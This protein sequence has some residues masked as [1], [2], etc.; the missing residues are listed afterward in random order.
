MS[1]TSPDV[2]R[3][4][5]VK[6]RLEPICPLSPLWMYRKGPYYYVRMRPKGLTK[7]TVTISLRTSNRRYAMSQVRDLQRRMEDFHLDNPEAELPALR[8]KLREFALETLGRSVGRDERGAAHNEY[9]DLI[10][11]MGE[12]SSTHGLTPEQLEAIMM[13]ARIA[14]AG[15]SKLNGA[16]DELREII[17]ELTPDEPVATPAQP[18][19][20]PLGED[21]ALPFS[22]LAGLYMAEQQGNVQASTL[23]EIKCSCNTIAKELTDANGAELNLRGHTR[24]DMN[25]LKA[26]LLEGRKASTVNKLLTR[27]STVM[28]WAVNNGYLERSFDKGLK[29]TKGADSTR[30]PFAKAQVQKL[31]D[32]ANKMPVSSWE[33]WALTIGAI[34]GAR[35]GEIYQLTKDDVVRLDDEVVIDINM[36]DDKTLKN[37]HS[38]RTIPLIDGAYGFKLKDFM[39]FVDSCEVRLFTAKP[40]YFNKPLNDTLRDILDLESGGDYSF[41]SLRHSMS[42]LM[43]SMGIS[44]TIAG[45]ILGHSTG[46]ITFDLYGKENKVNVVK[47]AAAMREA[48]GLTK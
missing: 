25:A 41:H 4:E 14:R 48:F 30:K 42:T 24:D 19:R 18:E 22:Y 2:T 35:V 3:L 45:D 34:T 12:I 47:M 11:D 37:K 8:E 31:M 7:E 5:T 39:A 40:H 6:K 29:I 33:R 23:H 9:V 27:M 21:A 43:R 26:R 17:K 13:V 28:T 46:T 10:H 20:E 16:P 36:D 15:I 44:S 1:I 32:H 38:R